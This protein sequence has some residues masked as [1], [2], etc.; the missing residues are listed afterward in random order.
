MTHLVWLHWY[1]LWGNF[2]IEKSVTSISHGTRKY[3]R[4]LQTSGKGLRGTFQTKFKPHANW[5]ALR[6]LLKR[7]ICTRSETS[8]TGTSAAVYT[9]VYQASGVNQGLLAAKSRLV[10]KGL[11]IPRLDLVSAHIAAN[12]AENVKNT[13]EGQPVRSVHGWLDSTVALHWIRREGSVYK[14]FVANWVNNIRD[15]AYIQWRHV[16][17]DQNL[18]DIGSRGCQADKLNELWLKGPE[19]LTEPDLWPGDIQNRTKKPKRKPNLWKRS[20]PPLPR[21]RTT[22]MKF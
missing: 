7:L 10:K 6:K 13:L 3:P 5:Q 17:T 4:R 2:C 9:V 22:L 16:G 20:L 12:L 11:T 14:Q 19:W 8:G 18:A 21:P 1:H 15:K